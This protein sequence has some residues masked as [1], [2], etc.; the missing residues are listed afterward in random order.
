MRPA[1]VAGGIEYA[2]GIMPKDKIL[3]TPARYGNQ[4]L[5][6]GVSDTDIGIFVGLGAYSNP[7]AINPGWIAGDYNGDGVVDDGDI[8]IFIGAGWYGVGDQVE[9]LW[10]VHV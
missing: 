5:F 4:N 3:I 8:T 10:E 1:N 6:R 7:F 9:G 2:T